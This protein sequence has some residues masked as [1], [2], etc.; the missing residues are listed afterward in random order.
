MV[1]KEKIMKG[2]F[3]CSGIGK[4]IDCPYKYQGFLSQCTTV[5]AKDA[6]E[7]I[8]E[9]EQYIKILYKNLMGDVSVDHT[10]V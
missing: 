3:C 1:N 6:L 4:C 7:L 10:P 2:L 5:L 9:Q 8:T